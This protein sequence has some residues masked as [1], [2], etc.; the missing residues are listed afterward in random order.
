M[1]SSWVGKIP[2]KRKWQPTP[3][4]LPGRFHGQRSLEGYSL[5]DRKESDRTEHAHTHTHTHHFSGF[6]FILLKEG[7]NLYYDLIIIR[8]KSCNIVKAPVVVP[9][10]D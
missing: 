2:W 4:F 8:I 3:V 1:F 10:T 5:W 9:G 6:Q 7:N